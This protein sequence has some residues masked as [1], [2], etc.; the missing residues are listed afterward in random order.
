MPQFY[1]D[2]DISKRILV[3]DLHVSLDKIATRYLGADE[4]HRWDTSVMKLRMD[5]DGRGTV[6][7]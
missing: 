7:Y 3:I 2:I 6:Q 4:V 5:R 1:L